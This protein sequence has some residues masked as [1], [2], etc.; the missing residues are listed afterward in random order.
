VHS[1][2]AS[3]KPYYARRPWLGGTLRMRAVLSSEAAATRSLAEDGG[4]GRAIIRQGLA[5]RSPNM[6]DNASALPACPVTIAGD[7]AG[8]SVIIEVRTVGIS[9]K[10][11]F[12]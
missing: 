3:R 11:P 6:V 8:G 2:R 7:E 5:D 12:K 1:G 10:N 4:R 9:T